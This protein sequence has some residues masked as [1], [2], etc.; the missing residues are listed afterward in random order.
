MASPLPIEGE[1]SYGGFTFPVE[2]ET[3]SIDVQPAYDESGRT[4]TH[5][6]ISIAI[7]TIISNVDGTDA[8]VQDILRRLTTPAAQLRYSNKGF[9]G[10]KINV[11][12]PKDVLWGPKPQLLG[13]KPIGG[14][15]ACEIT[16]RVDVAIPVCSDAV[17][18]KQIME[19][20]TR[21]SYEIDRSGYTKRTYSGFLRIPATRRSPDDRKLPDSADYYRDQIIPKL[22]PGFRRVPGTF[23]LS[24][25]KM[26]LDWSGV[27]DE[28]MGPNIPPPGMV[29]VD[30]DHNFSSQHGSLAKWVGTISATYEIG[31]NTPYSP[32]HAARFFL[33]MAADRIRRAM[34]QPGTTVVPVHFS[35]SEPSIYGKQKAK[36]SLAYAVTTRLTSTIIAT[37]GL[38]QPVPNSN[39]NSWVTSIGPNIGSRGN[40]QLIFNVNDDRILDLCSPNSQV[41]TLGSGSG[42]FVPI[43]TVSIPPGSIPPASDQITQLVGGVFPAPIQSQSWLQYDNSV[44]AETDSGTAILKRLPTQERDLTTQS[45]YLVSDPTSLPTNTAA[46]GTTATSGAGSLTSGAGRGTNFG[47]TTSP[48]SD[49]KPSGGSGD[50]F[51]PPPPNAESK[52]GPGAW[53]SPNNTQ[54]VV[55]VGTYL[56][57][58]VIIK[59]PPNN[60]PVAETVVQQ[61]TAPTIVIFLEGSAVRVGYPIPMPTLTNVGGVT[62]IPANRLD[63][64]EGFT[65][66]II[67][68]VNGIPIFG[69]RWRLRFVL[70]E[71]PQGWVL[72]PFNPLAS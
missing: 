51:N 63:M 68:S 28:Q 38:W 17:F 52:P 6:N 66:S 65:Q 22:L 60:P 19:L 15:R 69:A 12:G 62:P 2:T 5:N 48:T 31:L 34:S 57:R 10:L 47:G 21:L 27:V 59:N 49:P 37:S 64:G 55:W 30:A 61:R 26:R 32:S 35:F 71:M 9:G 18:E 72:P 40:A 14:R 46:S 23:T 3:E 20:S 54:Q 45:S 1:I 16:W 11:N 42:S 13:F 43:Q 8:T 29:E 36:F 41:Q 44:R 4:I 7:K 56:A 53:Q 50:F 39:W 67:G 33:T 58:P 70:P 24:P 25:D